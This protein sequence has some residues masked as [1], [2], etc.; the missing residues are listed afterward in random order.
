MTKSFLRK[1]HQATSR[2]VLA[3]ALLFLFVMSTSQTARAAYSVP[4]SHRKVLNLNADWKYHAGDLEGQNPSAGLETSDWQPVNVP[5]CFNQ[6]YWMEQHTNFG[7]IGWYQKVLP[8]EAS[9]KGRRVFLEFEGVFLHSW[10]YVNGKLAGEHKGGFT[11]FSLDITD[12]VRFGKDNIVTVKVSSDW[13]PQ[14]APRAGDFVFLGGIYRD[15]RLVVTDP[16]HVPWCG[17]YVTTPFGGK[18]LDKNYSLPKSYDEAPV[19]VRTE[20]RNTNAAEQ[21]CDVR[22]LVVDADG[23]VVASSRT[24]QLLKGDS[25]EEISQDMV[26][27]EPHFW[28]PADPYLYT[29]Y[30]EVYVGDQLVDTFK[31]PLGIRWFQCTYHEGFWLNGKH[32]PLHGFNVHQDHAGWGYAVPNSGFYRDIVL[33]R[34][35]GANFIRGSHYPKDPAL[36]DACD[37]YGLCL[38]HEL[39]YWGK[40]GGHGAAASPPKDSPDFAPFKKNVEDQLQEMIRISRNNPSIIIWSLTNEPTDGA[41]ATTPLSEFAKQLDPT[42]PTCRVTNF[43]HGEADIYGENG[44]S[45]RRSDSHPVIFTELWE[46]EAPRPGPEQGKPDPESYFSLGTARWAGFDYGTHERWEKLLNLVGACDNFRIPK[47]TYYWYRET[48]LD[49]DRPENPKPGTPATL[50]LT[51]SKQTIGT[52]GTDDC[53]LLV[54]VLDADGKHISNEL[55]VRLSIESGPGVFP[56]GSSIELDTPDGLAAMALHA[57]EPGTTVIKATAEGLTGDSVEI[58]TVAGGIQEY[59]EP[60]PWPSAS[61]ATTDAQVLSKGKT[62]GASSKEDSNPAW[63]AIDGDPSTRWCASNGNPRQRWWIDL[64]KVQKIHGVRVTFEQFANYRFVIEVSSDQQNWTVVSDQSR[65][66]KSSKVRNLSF[67]AE[68]RYVRIR[69]TGLPQNVWASHSE[70]EVYGDAE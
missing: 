2:A 61:L 43:S 44:Y 29:V 57:Y 62:A 41:L 36:I 35:C 68:G 18:L 59:P 21:Q 60:M 52:D 31:S 11:G 34:D 13:D 69:Y 58:E 37:R 6:P 50:Q 22:T 4:E 33:M 10:I 7:G 53:Q 1:S 70:V 63:H 20:V 67:E 12:H 5:H 9:W 40:G 39:C 65:N 8:V 66:K 56:T 45:P 26:V 46:K 17:T 51:A 27:Q 16:V 48:W 42:R 38:M 32:L 30:S 55:K 15:V 64:W 3:V 54:T 24:G 14:I 23:N 19:N 28:S 47:H 49:I 25:L